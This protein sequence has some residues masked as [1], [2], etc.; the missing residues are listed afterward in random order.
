MK[1]NTQ[2]WKKFFT[3]HAHLT[4]L[5]SDFLLKGSVCVADAIITC[6]N[7]VFDIFFN[8]NN[9]NRFQEGADMLTNEAEFRKYDQDFRSYIQKVD[10]EIVPKYSK[11]PNE[12]TKDE[13]KKDIETIGKFWYYYG[14]TEFPYVDLAY[15]K[16][17]DKSV[18][19]NLNY[20]ATDLK[21]KGRDIL[22]KF[23]FKHGVME[24]LLSYLSREFLEKDDARYL[25]SDELIRLFDGE[26]PAK[27]I[28]NERRD[29]YTT[30][31]IG[32]KI[33]RFSHKEALEINKKFTQIQETK[34]LRGIIANKGIARGR[35]II[36]PMLHDHKEI[37]KI[38]KM[39]KKGDILIAETTSPDTIMLCH[40]AKAIVAEQSGLLSHA[41][42]ISRELN[43]PCLIQV[44]TATR[45][46]KNGDYVEV[47]ANKGVVR[48]L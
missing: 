46:F 48:K 38:N 26:K 14:F 37:A 28:I 16:V 6:K 5:H 34:E 8:K 43:I 13:F 19:K 3:T 20:L 22:N 36:S 27:S 1:F 41:A 29:C 24:N 31:I 44:E 17:K 32:G 7:G 21:I 47:D 11:I 25:Y 39:M 30:A 42:I 2:D 45:V 9:E 12:L 40:K 35:A 18:Y 33:I 23:F 10:N 15:K 4:C